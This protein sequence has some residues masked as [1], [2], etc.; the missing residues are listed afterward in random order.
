LLAALA[1]LCVAYAAPGR[2][3][4]PDEPASDE[5]FD[6]TATLVEV[7][8]QPSG[9]QE[10]LDRAASPMRKGDRLAQVNP[11]AEERRRIE[12]LLQ[13]ARE[14][15]RDDEA[16]RLQQQL[17]N[18]R[19]EE[20]RQSGMPVSSA[21]GEMPPAMPLPE[22]AVG[23]ITDPNEKVL[24]RF[25]EA[26]D[27]KAFADFIATRLGINIFPDAALQ[28]KRVF[29][30]APVE[31]EAS[32][33]LKLLE[34]LLE[35]QGFAL[36]RDDALGIYKIVQAANIQLELG[37]EQA[38][39]R[40][41]QTP[42]L[43][44][45]SL[46]GTIQAM[47][48]GSQ[49]GNAAV[50]MSPIDEL[51]VLI[52]TGTPTTARKVEQ[53][54]QRILEEFANYRLF[55]FPLTN[56]AADHAV[57]RVLTLNGRMGSSSSFVGQ[58]GVQQQPVNPAIAG[59]G[60]IVNLETRLFADAANAVI[61][62]GTEP[63]AEQIGQLISIVDSVPRLI[64]RRYV[65]GKVAQLIAET[66][67]RIGLGPMTFASSTS[68]SGSNA[69]FGNNRQFNSGFGGAG[70]QSQLTGSGFVVD[71]D[72]ASIIYYGTES[73]HEQVA[74][75]VNT[76]TEQSLDE[77]IELQVYKLKYIKAEDTAGL[78]ND[79]I[80]DP[81]QQTFNNPLFPRG[82]AV[83][84]RAVQQLSGQNIDGTETGDESA[85]AATSENTVI[86]AD[87]PGNQLL[88]KAT[89]RAQ[90]QFATLIDT[91][92]RRKPQVHI[93][94]KIV[95][96]A[97]NDG[98][99]WTADVQFTAGQFAFL[100]TF[101]LTGPATALLPDIRT[102]PGTANGATAALIKSDFVPFAINALETIGEAR[103]VSN[104]RILVN[105]NFEAEMKSTREVPF[106][107]TQ[108][109]AGNPLVTSQGGI[110]EAGTTLKVKPRITAAGDLVLEYEVELS[111]FDEDN[112]QSNLQPP[113]NK[114]NYKSEVTL[115][116]DSTV[117]VGG[118]TFDR[119]GN[120]KQR[121][122]VLG[123]IPLLGALFTDYSETSR[124]TLVF[125]FI[126]PNV[127]ND[128]SFQDVLLISQG[129]MDEADIDPDRPPME[130]A[131]MKIS[132][133]TYKPS[134]LV[135]SNEAPTPLPPPVKVSVG[136]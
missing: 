26:V 110:A 96:V 123:W 55:N 60:G 100:S 61:F 12:T 90:K 89:A 103:V 33:L 28:D 113:K 92:D 120:S 82:N 98:F 91:M 31:V 56:V 67:E 52:V 122:P 130:P 57:Q 68:Q 11:M 39:T 83:A 66:G 69:G 24:I 37:G 41:I 45:S 85:L 36:V 8:T 44:P 97:T 131:M 118:F 81:S 15:G 77:N 53:F 38:T 127:L 135:P 10:L 76:F 42:M 93:Q 73:Q 126:T 132:E 116:T 19:R 112:Q 16:Q 51:G 86:V 3:P 72:T 64:A 65:A 13:R 88:I 32:E 133:F 6:S 18:M 124:K 27:L 102:V 80:Q 75:L 134:R 78:L 14:E 46:Q 22:G 87:E 101:G 7:D 25:G 115:P 71:L 106:S 49:G 20:A 17:D 99:D 48:T 117:V 125:V 94:A 1:G 40:V 74:D 111:D 2:D 29:F 4:I 43:R 47:L 62:R 59:G 5:S 104:P 105:D 70:Q 9:G 30:T 129:W 21:P 58:P 114:E 119:K 50:R 34:T 107:E 23:S 108:Q 54:V 84:Q 128:P 121:V 136:E 79:I 95:V 63:E 109:T 35:D